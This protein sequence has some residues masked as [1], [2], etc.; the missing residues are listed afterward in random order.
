MLK[1]E[2]PKFLKAKGGVEKAMAKRKRGGG[3]QTNG[4]VLLANRPTGC[5]R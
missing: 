5:Y 1:D 2:V 4:M 3:D